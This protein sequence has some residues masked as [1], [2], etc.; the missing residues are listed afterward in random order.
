MDGY[1]E[2]AGVVAVDDGCEM[3]DRVFVRG[4]PEPGAALRTGRRVI[5]LRG[6]YSKFFQSRPSHARIIKQ[7]TLLETRFRSWW[8]WSVA[9][10]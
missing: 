4:G 6:S 5:L 3:M 1:A 7:W 9:N 8:L 10:S 2:L